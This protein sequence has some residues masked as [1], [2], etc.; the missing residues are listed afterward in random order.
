M[1]GC[2]VVSTNGSCCAGRSKS[3][4]KRRKGKKTQNLKSRRVKFYTTATVFKHLL[5]KAHL[6]R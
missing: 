4:T 1:T 6:D 2:K 3:A 5:G